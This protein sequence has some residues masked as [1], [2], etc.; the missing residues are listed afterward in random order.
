M[1]NIVSWER[2]LSLTLSES[3]WDFYCYDRLD[4]TM[5]QAKLLLNQKVKQNL[6]VIAQAQRLARGRL[7]N[8]WQTTSGALAVTFILPVDGQISYTAFPLVVG[9]LLI[10]SIADRQKKLMIKWPND[11]LTKN[12]Q[13]IAGILVEQYQH[14]NQN[15]LS[16]GVGMNL[17]SKIPGLDS[18]SLYEAIGIAYHPCDLASKLALELPAILKTFQEFG[19]SAFQERWN[20]FSFPLGSEIEAN[21]NQEK[22]H[23]RYG[24]VDQQGRILVNIN[25]EDQSFTSLEISK[26]RY[27]S[28]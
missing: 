17:E 18:A 24:G 22:I 4:S 8:Q 3:D 21:W 23:G 27:V 5:D 26:V 2:E 13:K 7:G 25:N 19:F 28:S 15:F 16:I 9:L 20:N 10:E 11:I 6:L 1:H 12:G 14:K